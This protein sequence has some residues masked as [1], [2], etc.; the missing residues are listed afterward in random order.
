VKQNEPAMEPDERQSEEWRRLLEGEVAGVRRLRRTSSV[1]A[2]ESVTAW[3]A[4]AAR[5]SAPAA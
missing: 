1:G 3:I 4:R 2:G 5:A